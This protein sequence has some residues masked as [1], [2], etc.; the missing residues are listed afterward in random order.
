MGGGI[1]RRG[2]KMKGE[3]RRNTKNETGSKKR[4]KC[5]KEGT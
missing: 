5:K 1:T 4:K 3:G 2:G